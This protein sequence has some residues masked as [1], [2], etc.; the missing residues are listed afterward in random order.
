MSAI[1]KIKNII[2]RVSQSGKIKWGLVVGAV[3][4]FLGIAKAKAIFTSIATTMAFSLLKGDDVLGKLYYQAAMSIAYFVAKLIGWIMVLE[5]NILGWVLGI[6]RF[7]T[8]PVV[9]LGWRICRDFSFLIFSIILIAVAFATIFRSQKFGAK[10]LL[11]KV[12]LMAILINFSLTICGM[13]ID[14][15][16]VVFKFL[17]Y[18]P[19]PDSEKT[20]GGFSEALG[21][22]LD[23]QKSWVSNLNQ[24]DPDGSTG[25]L[26]AIINL[27]FISLAGFG[28]VMILG[29]LTLTIFVRILF[30]WILLILSPIAWT[31]SV[32]PIES[33]NKTFAD[34]S[35]NFVKWLFVGPV[36]AFFIFLIMMIPRYN[37][38]DNAATITNNRVGA[39]SQG[40]TTDNILWGDP[41]RR[42]EF[43]DVEKSNPKYKEASIGFANNDGPRNPA[44]YI[45]GFTILFLM[46]VALFVSMSFGAVAAGAAIKGLQKGA[47]V[48]GKGAVNFATRKTAAGVGAVAKVASPL[49]GKVSSFWDNQIDNLSNKGGIVGKF[50]GGAMRAMGGVVGAVSGVVNRNAQVFAGKEREKTIKKK[51]EQYQV[52]NS[53]GRKRMEEGGGIGAVAAYRINNDKES[54]VKSVDEFN[55]LERTFI[56]GGYGVELDQLRKQNP[57]FANDFDKAAKERAAI[58]SGA[59]IDE[60]GKPVLDSNKEKELQKKNEAISG[61]L[62][63]ADWKA[64]GGAVGEDPNFAINLVEGDNGEKKLVSSPYADAVMMLIDNSEKLKAV[65]AGIKDPTKKKLVMAKVIRQMKGNTFEEKV[66]NFEEKSR[67]A[68]DIHFEFESIPEANLLNYTINDLE[69]DYK[70]QILTP[71]NAESLDMDGSL[72]GEGA[73]QTVFK[74]SVYALENRRTQIRKE[75]AERLAARR[76][77]RAKS[78]LTKYTKEIFNRP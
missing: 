73:I 30:L 10:K 58:I 16:Q 78:G 18:A 29:I 52:L 75:R 46:I 50:S 62:A 36:F 34:W 17:I 22:L 55:R 70:T 2:K 15:S 57:H 77:K 6:D 8:I 71:D 49:A 35:K 56:T 21:D 65:L 11:F 41:E 45:Q 33:L 67:R 14:F 4:S 43:I 40:M 25:V 23:V 68:G 27:T 72:R 20:A 37:G 64:V 51:M 31:F 76:A 74:A 38:N 42:Q 26:A 48:A 39:Q 5:S 32:A 12:V 59:T 3:F 19:L 54:A 66:A 44:Y 53:E 61:I 1:T 47:K 13:A 28:F 9:Q 63:R 7:T 24:T 69:E 60:N